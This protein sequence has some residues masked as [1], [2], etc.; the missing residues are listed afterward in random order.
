MTVEKAISLPF[1]FDAYGKIAITT[2][3]AK[4]WADRVRSV[5]GTNLRERL[6]RPEFGSL[7]PTAFM[8]TQEMAAATVNA[9]VERAFS[10]QLD[11]LSLQSTDCSFDEYSGTMNV[12]I[13]YQLPNNNIIDTTVSYVYLS[14]NQP[15]YEE[16]L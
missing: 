7:V 4:I 9:E 12:T 16:N 11:K 13:T 1:S 6:M 14:N 15:I 8:E 10:T 3:Q 5:I 2:D